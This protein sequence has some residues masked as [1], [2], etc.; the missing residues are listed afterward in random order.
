MPRARTIKPSFFTDSKVGGLPPYAR[1]VF[2]GLWTLVDRNGRLPDDPDEIAAQ[3][4]PYDMVDDELLDLAG[5]NGCLQLLH[6]Q[7]LIRRYSVGNLRYIQVLNFSKHQHVY[8]NEKALYPEPVNEE[9]ELVPTSSNKLELVREPLIISIGSDL[10]LNS[11]LKRSGRKRKK[12][13]PTSAVPALVP[14]PIPPEY[15]QEWDQF[16]QHRKELKKP[17]TPTATKLAL[18]SLQAMGA[19]R[20][21]RT[22]RWTVAKGWQGLR[23]PSEQEYNQMF[24]GGAPASLNEPRLHLHVHRQETNIDRAKQEGFFQDEPTRDA[25]VVGGSSTR[26]PGLQS[27]GG[28]VPKL[29]DRYRN[30]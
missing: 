29:V 2:I 1:L 17:L 8:D 9:S 21:V 14:P 19:A 18:A 23:E 24:N 5:V 4:L 10:N 25:T 12:E 13:D 28:S 3:I 26:I 7:K 15:S 16:V 11:S 20:A 27:D 22:L 6:S 30:L